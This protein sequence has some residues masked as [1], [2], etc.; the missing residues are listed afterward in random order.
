M[1]RIGRSGVAWM[2]AWFLP[3]GTALAQPG[4][5]AA[6]SPAPGVEDLVREA[7]ARS[8]EVARAASRAT[9]ARQRVAPA[10]TPPDP[11]V[12]LMVQDV[13]APWD[14]VRPMSM[15]R[16]EWTQALPWPGKLGARRDAAAADADAGD[17][18]ADG[19]ARR[20]AMRVRVAYARIHAV[21]RELEAIDASRA[22]LEALVAAASARYASGQGGMEAV[23]RAR[24]ESSRLDERQ[25]DAT[26]RRAAWVAALNG[27]LDRPPGT[28]LGRV[29]GLPD[30]SPDLD[31][32]EAVALEK[33]PEI[34]AS[35]SAERAARRR[36]EAAR[37]DARPDFLVG[38][39][40]GTTL[41]GEPVAT[42]RLGIGL[43]VWRKGRTEPLIAAARAEVAAAGQGLRQSEVRIR[44]EFEELRAAWHRDQEQVR[45]YR[46]AIVPQWAV[47]V[48]A[49]RAAYLAGTGDFGTVVEDFRGWLDARAGLAAREA[50][51]FE[52]WARIAMLAA[53]FA[54]AA[55][56]GGNR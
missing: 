16:V 30:V 20:V 7:L 2:V 50:D 34:A 1:G 21:D 56:E 49:A 13:G 15:G 3:V 32:L 47:A 22:L 53:P 41:D 6:P 5:A 14:P 45:R 24:I 29:A 23:V 54:G 18:T 19:V 36:L 52:T 43:P 39:G 42:L 31:A 8:P 33:A 55:E 35:R 51:R 9:A 40:A 27:L 37:L 44:S 28:V 11:M 25:A 38:V 4:A 48:E 17:A 12:E 46:E 10:G 26:A